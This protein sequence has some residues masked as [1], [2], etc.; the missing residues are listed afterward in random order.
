MYFDKNVVI[1]KKISF[2]FLHEESE[3]N[4]AYGTDKNFLY[5]CAMSIAS[6][7]LHNK[8]KKIAF[9]IFT[10]HLENKEKE[11]FES[12]AQQYNSEINIYL[13]SCDWL[14]K[15][16]NDKNWSYAIYFRFIAADILYSS[17]D[18]ILYLDCDIICKGSIQEVIEKDI[19]RIIAAVV[20]DR[21]ETWWKKRAEALDTPSI[22]N[23]YF[24]SGVL[25]INLKNWEKE[26]ITE[27]SMAIL[28]DSKRVEKIIYPDQ[29]ALNI[30]LSQHIEF[31]D[32]KY[33][34]QYSINYEL[35]AKKGSFYP[36]PIN[37]K[38]VFIHYIGPTKPWHSWG[39]YPCIKPFLIAREQSPWC[40]VPLEMAV[41]TNQL[42]YCAKHLLK[43]EKYLSSF[44]CFIKYLYKKSQNNFKG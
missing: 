5:G 20:T 36:N 43:Q 23:G 19:S 44:L 13:V 29:D 14:K 40:T 27:K 11:K 37:E 6:I 21:D 22:A 9:H 26:S 10:D 30:L 12:L 24:N 4:I 1:E 25:L 41:S 32:K 33:N 28:T 7:L 15:L 39:E 3:L 42:R 34:T 17:K 2:S 31:I 16:P 18:K 35:K 38:T 8:E